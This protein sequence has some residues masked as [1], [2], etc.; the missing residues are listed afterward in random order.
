MVRTWKLFWGSIAKTISLYYVAVSGAN[1]LAEKF[2]SDQIDP[3]YDIA[4]NQDKLK[5]LGFY[6][7]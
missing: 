1:I 7:E 5:Q 3:S 2:V 4:A 6:V